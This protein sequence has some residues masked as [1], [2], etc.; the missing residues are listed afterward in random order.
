VTTAPVTIEQAAALLGVSASTIRR[1]IRAGSL[2]VEETRRPQGVVWLVHLPPGTATASTADTVTTAP[3]DTTAT[4]QPAPAPALAQAE[5]LTSL[6]QATIGAVLGPLIA[7][8]AELRQTVERMSGQIARQS[9]TIGQLRAE[10]RMLLASTAPESADPHPTSSAP[11]W[12]SWGPW[13][14]T[15]VVLAVVVGALVWPR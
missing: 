6:V 9:E 7:E 10:N 5:A 8:Q 14:L 15:V 3:V 13:L 4:A 12:R 2:Q 11:S 1:R